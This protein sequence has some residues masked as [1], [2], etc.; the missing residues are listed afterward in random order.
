MPKLADEL[1]KN[2]L[3]NLKSLTDR[4]SRKPPQFDPR[5]AKSI[6]EAFSLYSRTSTVN[7][8][9]AF[10][11]CLRESGW[12]FPAYLDL[13][14]ELRHSNRASGFVKWPFPFYQLF[15]LPS[16]YL[17]LLN[18]QCLQRIPESNRQQFIDQFLSR[19]FHKASKKVFAFWKAHPLLQSKREVISDLEK[20]YNAKL[21]G[22]CIPSILPLID[23]LMRDYFQTD[24]LRES[25]GT[26][27]KAFEINK[28]A[29]ESLK[30]GY[31][32][33]FDITENGSVPA[34]G[35]RV[36]D[37][38]EKDLRLP[39]VYLTSF[40]DFAFRYYSWH[41]TASIIED[42]NRHAVLHGD[43]NYWSKTQTTKVLMFFDLVV[44]LEPVLRIIIGT[45]K[46]LSKE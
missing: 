2:L 1:A 3:D 6:I 7:Y 23:Y 37:S 42:V 13:E 10:G 33:A 32:V 46:A 29:P 30:P 14:D 31:G 17:R 34:Q 15:S 18:L 9:V 27:V 24:D 12:P 25:I 5:W 16:I 35:R 43:M 22:T 36:A 19:R 26:F 20:A 28:L 41:T 45:E 38:V 11:D 21:W 8:F 44:K 39:G 4:I 40:V